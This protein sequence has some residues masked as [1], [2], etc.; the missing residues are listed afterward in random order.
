M[1]TRR[2]LLMALPAGRMGL[3]AARA[4]VSPPMPAL[5]LLRRDDVLLLDGP[6][7]TQFDY[8]QGLFLGIDND[9]LLKPFRRRAGL[10]APG[11]DM[12]GWY[13]DSTDFRCDPGNPLVDFH[14][15]IPGHGFGQYVSGLARGFAVT[16]DARVQAK[17][18]SL[19]EGYRATISTTFFE[20]YNLPAYTFDKLVIGLIDAY[21]YAGIAAAKP[22]LQAL[23]QV[24][25][26]VLLEKALTHEERRQRPH[27]REAQ[28]W[29]ETYTLP[30]NLLLAH[31]RG[32]GNDYQ[33]LGARFLQ[34]ERLFD[35]LARGENVLG[36]RHAYS[37][38]NALSSAVQGYLTLGDETL[39]R[40]AINCFAMI[41]A[42][43]Y[44]TGGWGPDEN[45][46]GDDRREALF[47]GLSRTHNSF[48]TPCGAYGHFK[49]AR[50]LLCLTRAS[51]HGD[52]MER[53]LYNTILGAKATEPDGSTFY[54][55]DYGAKAH[56]GFHR[57]RW[58][59]CSG[60]FVQLTA[61]YG[62]SAYLSDSSGL[63]VN[64]YVP[65]RVRTRV[66]DQMIT[67]TQN[68]DYPRDNVSR[69][70]LDL[71]TPTRF[72]LALRIPAWAGP[73]TRV[74]LNGRA[75]TTPSPG[76]FFRIEHRWRA[77]NRIALFLDQTLRLEPL[78]AAHP[79]LVALMRGPRVLFAVSE[80]DVPTT[81]ADLLAVQ[82]DRID[83][84]VW[85]G[86][87]EEDATSPSNPSPQS[88]TRLI[89]SIT[90]R[91]PQ[92]SR[93]RGPSDDTRSF[94]RRC[95]VEPAIRGPV[96]Q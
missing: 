39:L 71:R 2:N 60:T 22:T 44:A 78:S 26:P 54:Y 55:S 49:I 61:D 86:S 28:I 42:Q 16:R 37:H 30:E 8:Q 81:R 76:S 51:H 18:R 95:P 17:L 72:T 59:C 73:T 45:L 21:E 85:R 27:V 19:I 6:L 88:V 53:V 77:G 34:R 48:E 1:L 82:R 14:V 89:S 62:I 83:D 35:P 41:E 66:C 94:R 12:G 87:A 70:T 9:A 52:S 32:F 38:V 57:D 63:Y 10:P 36:G 91:L 40:A 7:R 65:S 20:D 5:S 25:L 46:A 50:H 75:L 24:A 33:T 3:A 68:T 67:L 29:D 4:P 43:S 64:L 69:F 15:F 80:P 79:E 58:P 13:D 31:E 90:K 23:T 96:L 84:E 92:C 74:T 11:A 47:E 93:V 56:K